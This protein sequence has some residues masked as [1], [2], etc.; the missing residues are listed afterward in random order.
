V[1]APTTAAP[2]T[3]A[4]PD[5]LPN[6][7]A[8]PVSQT[9]LIASVSPDE[10]TSTQLNSILSSG[11]PLLQSAQTTAAQQSAARGLQ[12]STLGTEAGT[13]ALINTATPIAE[14]NASTIANQT[15]QNLQTENN[16]GL[17]AAGVTGQE[18]LAAQSGQIQS[19]LSAQGAAQS[20]ALES[21]QAS[22]TSALTTQEA[23]E[24][25]TNL[26]QQGAQALTQI[27]AQTQGNITLAD[28][29]N[30]AA[31][32][33]SAQ[34]SGQNLTLTNQQYQNQQ[35]LLVT[36]YG[37]SLGLNTAQTQSQLDELNAQ[38]QNALSQISAN[39]AAYGTEYSEQL[40]GAYLASVAN[41]MS[42]TSSEIAQIYSTQGLTAEQQQAAVS[43][44]YSQMQ[45]NIQALGTYY[46]SSPQWN[47]NFSTGAT[48]PAPA[49]GPAPIP[50]PAPPVPPGYAPSPAPAPP[51]LKFPTSPAN[52][53]VA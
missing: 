30:A 20:S 13:Q 6:Q 27:A 33:L 43:T 47:P 22:E 35:A 12:N 29:N 7:T 14:A 25:L 5:G 45:S 31:A 46:S 23:A 11:S 8:T 49:N 21:Q 44:A 53:A 9:P 52:P 2:V 48:T 39:T 3:P 28:V 37:Q 4:P 26:S 40:G 34:E 17:Q 41:Y 16:F 24:Q 38:N 36:Q 19:G 42:S 1:A 32:T 51:S 18:E 10:L 15:S 50:Y